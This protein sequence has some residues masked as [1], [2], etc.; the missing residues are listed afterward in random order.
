[1]TQIKILIIYLIK[2]LEYIQF[3]LNDLSFN[4]NDLEAIVTYNYGLGLNDLSNQQS[5][6][7]TLYD[8]SNIPVIEYSNSLDG[9]NYTVYKYK[10]PSYNHEQLRNII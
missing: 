5:T 6:K 7:L 2:E 8:D 10:G 1:M 3:D 4:Y 9:N